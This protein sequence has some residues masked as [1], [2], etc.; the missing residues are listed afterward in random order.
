MLWGNSMKTLATGLVQVGPV[1]LL[2]WDWREFPSNG[3]REH[4]IQLSD[5]PAFEI[6]PRLYSCSTYYLTI[7]LSLL[8]VHFCSK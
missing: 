4:V 2:S 5:V 3:R 8:R 1:R 6:F 7:G